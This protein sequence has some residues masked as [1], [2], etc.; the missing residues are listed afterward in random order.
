M[1]AHYNFNH[2]SYR[3][4]NKRIETLEN[5]NNVLYIREIDCGH[6]YCEFIYKPNVIIYTKHYFE[7]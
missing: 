6:H 1:L 4:Q 3:K 2:L 5:Q 7:F